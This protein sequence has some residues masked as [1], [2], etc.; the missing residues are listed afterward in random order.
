[1]PKSV[2]IIT[3]ASQGIG[4]ATAIRLARDFSALVLVARSRANLDQTAEAVRGAGTEALV[5]DAD[6]AQP[7]V[8][9]AVVDR[10][11]AAFGR[12]DALLN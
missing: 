3:G 2:A 11:L 7:S 6:L 5:I 8:A 1:M 4:Q 10:A 12:I 9:Q